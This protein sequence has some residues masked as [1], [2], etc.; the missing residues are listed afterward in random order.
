M[1]LYSSGVRP[2]DA[3]ASG[4][5]AGSGI[6]RHS[7]TMLLIFAALASLFPANARIV[8]S[9]EVWKDRVIVLWMIAPTEDPGVEES[10]FE[11]LHGPHFHGPTR[12][13]LVDSAARHITNTIAIDN[14]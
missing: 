5:I 11:K 14:P 1:R 4:V 6:P 12:V 13:S 3:M 8:E 10:C 7:M 2:C 9:R